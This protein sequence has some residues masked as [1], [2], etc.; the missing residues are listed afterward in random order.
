MIKLLLVDDEP[1]ILEVA[2]LAL[3]MSGEF[4][5]IACASGA[6]AIDRARD[7]LP[8]VVLLDYRMPQMRGTEV[9]DRLRKIKGLEQVPAI[10]LTAQVDEASK[11]AL[12]GLGANGVIDKPFDPMTLAA[13]VKA[14]LKRA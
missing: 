4:D 7:L 8:E 14:F 11:L 13:Q 3:T 12:Q 10:F 5:I 6:E 9:L 1:D 2:E